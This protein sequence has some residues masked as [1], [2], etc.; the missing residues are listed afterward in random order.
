MLPFRYSDLP[1]DK[2]IDYQEAVKLCKGK[3]VMHLGQLKLFFCELF[4]LSCHA[5]EK[6]KV[7]YVGAAGGYHIT[8]LAD[9]FPELSFDL[10][11]PR[12]FETEARPN[13]RIYNKFFTNDDAYVYKNSSDRILFMCD[14]RN[15]RISQHKRNSD[16]GKM[17]QLVEDDMSMQL[18]WCQIIQPHYAYLKFRLA[19]EIAKTDYLSGVIYLQPYFRLSTETRLM[20]ND[21]ETIIE[22]DNVVYE[23]RMAYF[24]GHVRCASLSYK[25]YMDVM[26]QYKLVNNWDNSLALHI[27]DCYLKKVK[28]K[29]EIG[30]FFMDIVDFHKRKYGKKY[31]ILFE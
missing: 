13:I 27:C 26:K 25:E 3:R 12:E 22:Y 20:T 14:I 29:K 4:F 8:K 23:R 30:K 9:L 31:D 6:D 11:D 10:W 1:T 24:N 16:I 18:K 5:K 17:D 21:Y 2:M 7:L 28:S 19:Y 15:M